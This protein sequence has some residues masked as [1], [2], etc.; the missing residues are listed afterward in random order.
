MVLL[1][2]ACGSQRKNPIAKTFH[3]TAAHFN[4]HYNGELK[5]R[6]GIN[7][8]N[9]NY[10]IPPEGYVPALV[11]Q[12]AEDAKSTEQYFT[13]AQEKAEVGLAKHPN[14]KCKDDFHFLIG[15]AWFFKQDYFR[16]QERFEYVLREFPDTKIKPEV[17]L[18]LVKTHF[19]N[20]NMIS[21]NEILEKEL[22]D[23]KLSKKQKGH[24][25]LIKAQMALEQKDFEATKE[26]LE[27]NIDDIKGKNNRARV[28]FLLGQL[29]AEEPKFSKAYEHYR[30]VSRMNTD[31]EFV[32]NAKL[33]IARLY[34]D[35]QEGA[36]ESNRIYKMLRKMLRDEKNT[37]FRDQIYY[38][39]ALLDLKKNDLDQALK[40]LK[41]SLA[42]NT[43]NP[44][45]KALA[46]YKIGQIYFYEKKDYINAQV[47]FDSA[48][49]AINKDAPEYPEISTI[50]KTLKEYVTALN[51]I[52]YQDSMV[53]LAGLDSMALER[54]INKIVELEK[55]RKEEEQ[56]RQLEEMN[57]LNDPNLFNNGGNK[58]GG[59]VTTWPFD[60]PDQVNQGRVEFQRYWGQRKNEDN[61][62]RKTKELTLSDN[63]GEEDTPVDS[64]LVS[65]YGANRA[66]YY[67]DIP[68]T[69]EEVAKRNDMI[70]EAMFTLGQIYH[71]KLNQTDSAIVV[72]KRLIRKFPSHE[73]SL[74]AQYALFKIYQVEDPYAAEEYA[75]K[76]CAENP[77]GIYCR[78]CKNEDI[79]AEMNESLKEYQSAYNALYA[80]YNAGEY[81]TAVNFSNFMLEKYFTHEKVAQVYY[82]K[83]LA[84]GK[85]E[86]RDS[87]RKVFTYI[88]NNFPDA[89]VTPVVKRT[90]ELM[91]QNNRN[92]KPQ[93]DN[94]KPGDNKPGDESNYEGFTPELKPGDQYHVAI[95]LDKAAVSSP[96]LQIILNN[97][98]STTYGSAGLTTMIYFYQTQQ[99]HLAYVSKF[100]NTDA[101][102]QYLESIKNLPELKEI[103][104]KPDDRIVF[105]SPENFVTA[106]SKKRFNDYISWF[107]NVLMKS[108]NG[109]N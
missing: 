86:Q 82:V 36:D 103:M 25:T 46:Y 19:A 10:R 102:L 37:D 28:H 62:N 99:K 57:Q 76:I 38:E 53:Y 98:N 8:I 3:N 79:S 35:N 85:L 63:S 23:L 56:Q 81:E 69:P 54:Q 64:G 7:T 42:T 24:L 88:K 59:P 45:Q 1:L 67:K 108:L 73:Y 48:S 75:K 89:E 72:Y 52:H 21:A 70:A 17:L 5:Y 27:K 49:V 32:F 2:S 29:Y 74:K 101:A 80:S 12:N 40:D 30:Y 51:T 20:G 84:F 68:G 39:M 65:K 100:D 83:G 107:D 94:G 34:V 105:I 78:L 93:G 44:R 15:R 58:P 96:Q 55:K 61:W 106:Y 104:K 9:G 66:K 77:T 90:L 26:I 13:Q 97:Y 14:A 22:K 92:D 60:S 6:E 16:A 71:S 50:S 4:Y 109:G 91:D 11:I 41:S 95:L 43:T 47:Y 33:R 18:W 31:Y 87:L